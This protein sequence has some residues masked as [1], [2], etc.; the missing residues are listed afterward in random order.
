MNQLSFAKY[1]QHLELILDIVLISSRHIMWRW[2]KFLRLS[3]YAKTDESYYQ[4]ELLEFA[5]VKAKLKSVPRFFKTAPVW[6]NEDSKYLKQV[7]FHCFL[8]DPRY[9]INI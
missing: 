7:E 5:A 8:Y 4:T 1:W 2:K 6:A 3:N 9:D